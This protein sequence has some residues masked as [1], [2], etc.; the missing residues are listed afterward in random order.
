MAIYLGIYTGLLLLGLSIR[1][2]A[3]LWMLGAAVLFLLIFMGTRYDTGCDFKGYL[4]R[5]ELL[6]PGVPLSD[7]FG[8]DEFG[9]QLI[10]TFV[11]SID[12]SYMWVNVIST[13]VMLTNILLFLRGRHQPLMMLA[14]F[15]PILLIQLGMSGLRQGI[16]VSFLMLACAGFADGSRVRTVLWIL[17][18]SIF[19]NSVLMFLPIVAFVGRQVSGTRLIGSI[20]VVAPVAML[21]LG[22]RM[23]VYQARYVDQIYGQM[24]SGAAVIRYALTLAPYFAIYF[25]RDILRVN[26]PKEYNLIAL[27]GIITVA[28]LPVG[29][30][31]TVALHR[32]VYYLMPFSILGFVYLTYCMALVARSRAIRLAPG[33]LY[34]AYS[35][36]WFALSGH[37]EKCYLPYQSYLFQ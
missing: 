9:F 33:F 12:A 21:L 27:F 20:V 6:P 7:A 1:R 35:L 5:F 30:I 37:A 26:F 22:D 13:A 3:E 32:L 4:N 25:Y 2:N 15:F 31:N 14:V 29:L 11:R 23:D 28:T 19:H 16:A 10:L 8:R 17:V 24:S 36:S 18:G 34:G